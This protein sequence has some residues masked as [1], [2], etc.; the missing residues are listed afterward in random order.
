MNAQQKFNY[1][2]VGQQLDLSQED[3]ET[4]ISKHRETELLIASY[5]VKYPGVPDDEVQE[6]QKLSIGLIYDMQRLLGKEKYTEYHRLTE[7]PAT[8][9]EQD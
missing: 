4:F 6:I 7:E 1:T 5:R 2:Q 9:P 3:Y 8:R